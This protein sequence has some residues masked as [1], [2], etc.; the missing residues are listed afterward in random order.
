[1]ELLVEIILEVYMELMLLVVPEEKTI[2]KK[3][4]IIV[5]IIALIITF[6]VLALG[7][8]G[9]VLVFEMGRLIGIIPLGLAIIIS[10]LQ[11]VFGIILHNKKMKNL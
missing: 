2:T 8:W 11:I 4:R 10:I 3:H 6:G 9:G 5:G 7:V 1:M